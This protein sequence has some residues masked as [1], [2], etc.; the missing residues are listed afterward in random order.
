MWGDLIGMF[1]KYSLLQQ[2]QAADRL[3]R[4]YGLQ[5][6]PETG[7]KYQIQF[8]IMRDHCSLYLDTTGPGL[9][10]RGYRAVGVEAPLRET[11]AAGQ[12][13]L[14]ASAVSKRTR[15]S[16]PALTAFSWAM[17]TALG[18]RPLLRIGDHR[19]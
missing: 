13:S 17:R 19:H 15:S 3:G 1:D 12:E 10:K 11:L 9:H 16:T 6:L 4:A 18:S 8:A 14:A 5:R 2:L 7:A